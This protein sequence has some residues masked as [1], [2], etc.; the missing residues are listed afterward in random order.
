[1][2]YVSAAGRGIRRA[3]VASVAALPALARDAIGIVGAASV[4]FGV[5]QIYVPAAYIAGG[6]ILVAVALAWA[7]RA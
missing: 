2:R 5:W 7:R 1:M 4:V 6:L 3:A